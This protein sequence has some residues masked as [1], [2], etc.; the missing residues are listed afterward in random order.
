MSGLPQDAY[1]SEFVI[2][3]PED[4]SADEEIITDELE[5]IGGDL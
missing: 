4:S 2:Q 5:N 1:M 3:E